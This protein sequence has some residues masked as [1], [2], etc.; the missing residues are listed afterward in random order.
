MMAVFDDW[1]GYHKETEDESCMVF[2]NLGL[3][4]RLPVKD[5]TAV[6]EIQF[7]IHPDERPEEV[8]LLKMDQ[9]L[10]ETASRIQEH[11]ANRYGGIYAGRIISN[12]RKCFYFYV[13]EEDSDLLSK[14][15]VLKQPGPFECELKVRADPE[16]TVYRDKL[17]PDAREMQLL[18]NH[19]MVDQ[20]VEQGE[21]GNV[22]R[23]IDHWIYFKEE[24]QRA[25]FLEEIVTFDFQ[26]EE[27]PSAQVD[28]YHYGAQIWRQERITYDAVD[29]VVMFL[30]DHAA[31]YQGKYDG[32]ETDNPQA[33]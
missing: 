4:Q 18:I 19:R 11:M 17:Y 2:L 22:L 28:E 15:T 10:A 27:T 25:A 5:K 8:F 21:P 3:M 1:N 32:W 30:T 29:Y 6:L 7:C 26:V 20:L 14:D 33:V 16:W 23:R 24:A 12:A 31:R 13:S 9:A